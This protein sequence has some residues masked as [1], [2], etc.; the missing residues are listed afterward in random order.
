MLIDGMFVIL[1]FLFITHNGTPE[2][3]KLAELTGLQRDD[4]S[5]LAIDDL[6]M[7][8]NSD[9]CYDDHIAQIFIDAGCESILDLNFRLN[10]IGD[11]QWLWDDAKQDTELSKLIAEYNQPGDTDE[12]Y[13]KNE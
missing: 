3:R 9:I 5:F 10:V 13:I 8:V 7:I 1:T 4:I 6:K 11:F 2:G 12:E